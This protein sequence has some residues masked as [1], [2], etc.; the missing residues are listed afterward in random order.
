MGATARLALPLLS[1]GQAQ[2]EFMHNEALQALDAVVAA[3]V[4][5]PPRASPPT[6]PALGATYIVSS[7]PGG[8]WTGKP[9]YLACYTAGG[10]RY[11]SP[12][13]GMFA[14]VRSTSTWATFLGGAWELGKVRASSLLVGGQQVVGSRAAAIA[15]PS[16]GTNVDVEARASL[17]Q[18]LAALRQHGL[19]ET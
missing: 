9:L 11:V 2:K 17:T 16:G 13:D 18:I 8:A 7:S 19:I 5:E 14:F 12:R 3:A 6:T 15:S 1:A 10:W 4:E